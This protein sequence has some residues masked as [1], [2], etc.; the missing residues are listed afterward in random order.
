MAIL[1]YRVRFLT[2]GF[3]GDA[4]QDGR[5][6]TPPFKALLR[7]WWRVVWAA[8]HGFSGSVS[9]MRYEEGR[10]FGNAWLK[11]GE[12]A[13]AKTR[14]NKSLVR[15]RLDRWDEGRER[16][17]SG[18]KQLIV[19]EK[20]EYF[21]NS[22]KFQ[23]DSLTYLGFGPITKAKAAIQAGECAELSLAVLEDHP[24]PEL[25]EVL[26]TNRPRLH[27]ALWL[28]DRYG[29]I[30]GRSRN[31]WGSFV[32]EPVGA[33]SKLVGATPLLDWNSALEQDWPRAIGKDSK[34]PLIWQTVS[35]Y[36][37]WKKLMRALAIVKLGLRSQ[38]VFM[39]AAM[40]KP[41]SRHWLSYP[42]TKHDVTDWS[43]LRLPNT[44]R[45]KIRPEANNPRKLVGVIFHVPCKPPKAFAPSNTQIA[46]VWQKVYLLL[47]ELCL[48][49]TPGER[50]FQFV[51][52]P[53]LRAKLLG[54]LRD[55]Q[56]KR[57]R[58]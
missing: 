30:G 8:D 13:N 29:T 40:G 54:L 20:V 14:F 15:L 32:L 49:G 52:N 21:S 27:R 16:A 51:T 39:R 57:I 10:L 41:Q 26:E 19:G 53:D 23:I 35:S 37:D 33:N 22:K 24:D 50:K 18:K 56:L 47:D 17:P 11:S 46:Q 25:S 43:K 7:Q 42:V 31:G 9:D 58:E 6:R 4:E 12:G 5:W 3:L 28:M 38:F 36:E 34:G 48:G 45:F 55:V 2:P 1:S 44:L